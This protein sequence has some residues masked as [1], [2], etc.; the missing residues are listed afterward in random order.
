[1]CKPSTPV[2]LAVNG[3][4]KN[5][6]NEVSLVLVPGACAG[7]LKGVDEVNATSE[8][9]GKQRAAAGSGCAAPRIFS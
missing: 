4:S 8:A 1:M 2:S 9:S 6:V 3:L 7:F 5:R